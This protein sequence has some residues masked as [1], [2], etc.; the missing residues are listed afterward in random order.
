[1]Y[2]KEYEIKN[3]KYKEIVQLKAI[4][5]YDKAIE[6]LEEFNSL[7]PGDIYGQVDYAVCLMRINRRQEGV[8][9][10]ENLIKRKSKIQKLNYI[11]YSELLD[12]YG[13]LRNFDKCKELIIDSINVLDSYEIKILKI[14]YLYHIGLVFQADYE[15]N[16]IKPKNLK[17]EAMLFNLKLHYCN[18]NYFRLNRKEIETKLKKYVN[19]SVLSISSARKLY[20]K[21]YIACNN[22]EEA[23]KYM[24]TN[25]GYRP[26]KIVESYKICDRLGKKEEANKFLE[27]LNNYDKKQIYG[28]TEAEI[29]Y[30]NGKKEEAYN[31]FKILSK[32]DIDSLILLANYSVNMNKT[33]ETIDVIKEYI[34]DKQITNY[35]LVAITE[36]LIDFLIY[37]KRYEEAYSYLEKYGSNYNKLRKEQY[38]LYLTKKLNIP[39]E[40]SNANSYFINQLKNYDYKS[41]IEHINKHKYQ[42]KEKAVHTVF[43]DDIEVNE[44]LN[45]LKPHLTRENLYEVGIINKY[46][47]NCEKLDINENKI[48]VGLLDDKIIFCFP[49]KLLSDELEELDEEIEYTSDKPKVKRLTQIEKF[50]KKYNL[51]N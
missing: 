9:I 34:S 32:N 27:A 33:N 39:Y 22:D 46:E 11:I 37:E 35:K 7:Y 10:L 14:K 21:L 43:N 40:P 5:E 51:N 6:K 12:T 42:N 3:K 48:I 23:Y 24:N 29:L 17:D 15:L 1:M 20:L 16:S 50:Y 49:Y 28:N 26:D 47:I 44:L 25:I 4:K 45:M 36:R 18:N 31:K 2:N 19:K 30:L 13:K 41:V 8:E 38:Y